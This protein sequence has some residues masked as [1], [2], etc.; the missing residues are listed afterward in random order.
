MRKYIRHLGAAV[1]ICA[2]V[3]IAYHRFSYADMTT[4]RWLIEFWH[5]W[6]AWLTIT[7]IGYKMYTYTKK[8]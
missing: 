3:G 7:I 5:V 4:I 8:R 2:F 6:L 1:V